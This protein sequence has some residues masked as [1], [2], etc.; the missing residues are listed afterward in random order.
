M[1]K[2]YFI[3]NN[4]DCRVKNIRLAESIPIIRPEE[5]IKHIQI[6]GRDGDLTQ[7]EGEDIYNPYIQTASIQVMG[8][9]NVQ[10]VYKWLRGSGYITFHGEPNRKQKA[11]VIGA[12]TLK[13][14]SN[15]IDTWVG[16]TQFYCDPLKEAVTTEADIEVTES[17]TTVNNPG[18]V[19]SRPLIEITG[20]G[21]ITISI[22]G[23]ALILTD[24]ESGT[25]IDSDMQ[26]V[27]KNGIAL[28]DIYTG[29]F[30]ILQPGENTIQ[31]TG[32]ISKLTITPRW[33][34]L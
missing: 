33:R 3:W 10:D 27:T 15:N 34:Y 13:K 24:V 4:T 26:L 29:K 12:V 17:G 19:A 14:F 21:D 28:L 9:E 23:N 20:S 1:G 18:D 31:F 25:V 2:I 7:L 30:P 6:P 8:A 32:N 16:E 22:G 5:R 11:R